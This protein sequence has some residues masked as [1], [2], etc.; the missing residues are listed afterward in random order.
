MRGYVYTLEVLLA[1][2]LV[3]TTLV[4]LYK[5]PPVKPQLEVSGMKLQGIRALEYLDKKGDLRQF[6]IVANE[7]DI[8]KRINSTLIRSIGFETDICTLTCNET[9]VPRN[10]TVVAV[11]YYI[12]GYRRTHNVTKIKMW[13]WRK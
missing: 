9:G 1:V 11:D 13:M 10:K 3:I 7:T 5:T 8:E 6:A 12:A 4:F 2:S